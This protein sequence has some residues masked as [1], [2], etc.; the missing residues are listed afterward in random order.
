MAIKRAGW[1]NYDLLSM[2]GGCENGGMTMRRLLSY[3]AIA[4]LISATST[5]AAAQYYVAQK[6]MGGACSVVT[7]KPDGTKTM[8][9]GTTSY[10]THAAAQAALKAAAECK[11]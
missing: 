8:M 5:L 10:K 3:A 4:M 11:K 9:V 1:P 6:G 7:K 2:A